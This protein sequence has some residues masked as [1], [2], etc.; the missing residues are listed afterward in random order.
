MNDINHIITK[1]IRIF[2]SEENFKEWLNTTNYVLGD[3]KPIDLL[4][5]PHGIDLVDNAI[6]AL[7]W[8]N[9]M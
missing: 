9:V 4:K 7:S 8:G 3:R 1:G 6:E 5:D 2:G